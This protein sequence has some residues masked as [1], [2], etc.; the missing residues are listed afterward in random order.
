MDTSYDVA[1]ATGVQLSRRAANLWR[2]S[3]I[4]VATRPMFTVVE[5]VASTLPAASTDRYSTVC[6][7]SLEPSEGAGTTRLVPAVQDPPSTRYSV[8]ATPLVASE[9][10]RLT[11]TGVLRHRWPPPY[12]VVAGATAS[13]L[14]DAEFVVSTRPELSTERYSI[15]CRPSLDPSGVAATTSEVPVVQPVPSTLYSVVATPETSSEADNVTV[16]SAVC[17]APSAPVC[18]VHRSE[19]VDFCLQ[20]QALEDL[21]RKDGRRR[22]G[23]PGLSVAAQRRRRRLRA[24]DDGRPRRGGEGGRRVCDAH[25]DG[26]DAGTRG[27]RPG[28]PVDDRPIGGRVAR[29]DRR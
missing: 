3:L 21:G 19:G 1:S 14:S 7:P 29:V 17:Q 8:V 12:W 20:G 13:M 26:D 16:T 5:R 28:S 6:A 9:A 11:V 24:V 2:M 18:V 27:A 10:V 25:V 4:Q 23:H 15:V 22:E